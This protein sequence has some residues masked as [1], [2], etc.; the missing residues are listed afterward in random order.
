MK[1]HTTC[2]LIYQPNTTLL[3]KCVYYE[4]VYRPKFNVNMRIKCKIK[5][6]DEYIQMEN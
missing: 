4:R 6:H 1:L 2:A 3:P 5:R